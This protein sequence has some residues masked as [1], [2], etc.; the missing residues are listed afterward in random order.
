MP[1][2]KTAGAL[3]GA[4]AVIFAAL[5]ALAQSEGG[6]R[7]RQDPS[8][9]RQGVPSEQILPGRV[10]GDR[11]VRQEDRRRQ[12][13]QQAQELSPDE[14]RAGA[15]AIVDSA[16]ASCQ[17]AEAN[18]L[19]NLSDGAQVYE[20]VCAAGP[21]YML[22]GRTPPVA[23]NCIALAG[24][25]VV[26]R[27]T[28]PNVDAGLQCQLPANQ[29]HLEVIAGYAREAGVSCE[30]DQGLAF[31]VG[32]YEVG[33][34]NGEGFWL[35]QDGAEWR[36]VSCMTLKYD[37]ETCRYT[38]EDELKG[39][40]TRVLAAS[41]AADCDVQEARRMGLDARR[42]YVFELKCSADRG[43]IVRVGEY[44]DPAAEVLTCSDGRGV[45]GGCTLTA[46]PPEE[47]DE[48]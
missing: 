34:P 44:Y 35:E 27:E 39:V 43:Y 38:T 45:G 11:T 10:G 2:I 29:N 32:R 36:R 8:R 25:A 48:D 14:L 46:V 3:V 37:G 41:P 31:G 47:E 40:W 13:Q 28:D 20:A 1:Q 18:F 19:G 6:D 42:N 24:A 5:P 33:C 12:Q 22:V 23:Q 15:Q 30:I 9:D 7:G 26:A 21:G 17:V 16:G 4:A